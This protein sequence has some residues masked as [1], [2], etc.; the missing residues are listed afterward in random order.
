MVTSVL[1]LSACAPKLDFAAEPT[2]FNYT[3]ANLSGL[4]PLR[5]YPAADDVCQVIRE[6]DAIRPDPADGS[7]LIAC[8]KH[9]KGALQ[10]R[11]GERAKVLAHARHWT[12]LS[13][14]KPRT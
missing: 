12:I 1:A 11:I 4:S 14:A 7:I 6:N 2:T 10:D 8:P 9:E 13:V 5:A 3:D